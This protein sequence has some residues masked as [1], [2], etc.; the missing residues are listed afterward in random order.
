VLSKVAAW[1]ESEAVPGVDP[2]MCG[3][4]RD[5]DLQTAKIWAAKWVSGIERK[6]WSCF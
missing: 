2:V 3:N 4:W 5:H 6:G 1:P